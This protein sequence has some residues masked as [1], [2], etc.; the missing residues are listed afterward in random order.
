MHIYATR[1]VKKRYTVMCNAVGYI[2][3]ILLG[4]A[5]WLGLVLGF[6]VRVMAGLL[7]SYVI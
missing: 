2:I 5:L 3:N 1:F 6:N 7:Q 4:L